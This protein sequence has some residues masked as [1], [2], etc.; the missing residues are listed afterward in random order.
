M[1][2]SALSGELDD[3]VLPILSGDNEEC[4][5]LI[6]KVVCHYFFAPCGANG[7]LHLPLSVC[8]EECNYVQ[9]ACER[10][11]SSVN[12]LLH[13]ATHLDM[14]ICNATDNHLRDLSLCCVDANIR[15][16]GE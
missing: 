7:L 9:S 15:I 5:D 6:S 2:Q 8:P 11:W 12:G 16:R 10:D 4:N 13:R 14:I 3:R 1:N